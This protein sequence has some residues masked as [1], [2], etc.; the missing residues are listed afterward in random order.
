VRIDPNAVSSFFDEACLVVAANGN[1]LAPGSFVTGKLNGRRTVDG[2]TRSY[3]IETE[4]IGGSLAVEYEDGTGAV[5][6]VTIE[7]FVKQFFTISAD[8]TGKAKITMKTTNMNVATG[9]DGGTI[10]LTNVN[11]LP[12]S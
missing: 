9:C 7:E 8:G 5:T 10:Q 11:T 2:H 6:S 12:T 4:G 1:T 3:Y